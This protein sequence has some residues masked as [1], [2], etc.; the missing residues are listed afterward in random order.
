M[1][2]PK[3][4]SANF[5]ALLGVF[6][7]GSLSSPGSAG[8][9]DNPFLSTRLAGGYMLTQSDETTDDSGKNAAEGKCGGKSEKEA[10][11]GMY[12]IGSSH[13]DESKVKDGKCGGHKAAEGL[14]GGA[15]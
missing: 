12:V 9:R 3:K 4:V 1:A 10:V 14:C 8:A 15:R 13:E 5:P 7:V 2:R 6:M 11:C